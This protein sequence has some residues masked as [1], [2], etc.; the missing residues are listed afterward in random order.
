MARNIFL[1]DI[2]IYVDCGVSIGEDGPSQMALEDLGMFRSLPGCTVFYPSD[3]VATERAVELAANVK[4]NLFS[5]DVGC[6]YTPERPA[7]NISRITY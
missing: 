3:A 4:V 6:L 5:D 7:T 2:L 1:F